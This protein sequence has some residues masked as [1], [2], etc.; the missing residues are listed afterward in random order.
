MRL[1]V[2]Q[3]TLAR[4]RYNGWGCAVAPYH[5]PIVLVT[6]PETSA[7]A[8]VDVLRDHAGKFVPL[9]APAFGFEDVPHSLP[10]FDMAIFTSKAGVSTA[11]DGEGRIAWCVGDMT[12]QA[13]RDNGYTARS[14][15]GDANALVEVILDRR[16]AG[17]LVHIRGETSHGNVSDR[18]NAA[19]LTCADVISYRK[20]R[21]DKPNDLTDILSAGRTIILPI[22]SAETVSI[23]Q[24]WGLPLS[25]AHIVAISPKVGRM[26]EVM[27]PIAVTVVDTPDVASMTQAVVRLIA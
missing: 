17:S 18:L 25:G 5:N 11:P 13:A 19:G 22:F 4:N 6:R 23:I 20:S 16:P 2:L 7:T 15:Q 27:Q 24:D 12:A 21:R 8:F 14:A 10:P 26:T 3:V 1:D 9:I